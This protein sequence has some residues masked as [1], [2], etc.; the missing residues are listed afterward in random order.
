MVSK[1]TVDS[2]LK[3]Y[4]LQ[5]LTWGFEKPTQILKIKNAAGGSIAGA[6]V[7]GCKSSKGFNISEDCKSSWRFSELPGSRSR[8]VGAR[9]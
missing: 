9:L 3:I 4:E 5:E 7:G 6:D 2:S 1:L 8:S